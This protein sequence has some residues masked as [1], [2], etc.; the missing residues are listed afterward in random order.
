MTDSLR[1][2]GGLTPGREGKGI[3]KGRGREERVTQ[4]QD[5]HLR[6]AR[7]GRRLALGC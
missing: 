6:T 5:R 4:G 2:H 1:T 3:R 7:A